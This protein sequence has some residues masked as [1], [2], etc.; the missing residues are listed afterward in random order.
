MLSEN[1]GFERHVKHNPDVEHFFK[2]IVFPS[3]QEFF[4][5]DVSKREID[6]CT[7]KIVGCQLTEKEIDNVYT[8]ICKVY[9]DEM[10]NICEVKPLTKE[11]KTS[12]R[13]KKPFWNNELQFLWENVK[14]SEKQFLKA[15][16][17]SNE[18]KIFLK[19]LKCPG[20]TLI[21]HTKR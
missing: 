1:N 11:R 5:S 17:G 21:E 14:Q 20:I 6:E 8:L 18:R 7:G 16:Q 12:H 9:Y 15:K 19:I 10:N 13:V 4:S 3:N 2:K